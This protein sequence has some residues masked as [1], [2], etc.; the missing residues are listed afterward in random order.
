MCRWKLSFLVLPLLLA[1]CAGSPREHAE[2]APAVT[3]VSYAPGSLPPPTQCA[4]FVREITGIPLRG[5]AWTWW[6][7][8]AGRF[9]RGAAPKVDSVLV[10]RATDQLPYGHVA[11][12]RRVVG[13]REITVTHA[14]WGGDDPTR[15]LVHDS[16]P[17]VDVSPANDWS[18]LRFWN[19]GARAFGKVYAAYGFIYPSAG[20]E[21]LRPVW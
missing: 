7:Q 18:E 21:A 14:D 6:D 15:R 12:V 1:A 8:A 16:M 3:K 19:P 17:V 13:P 4:P 2:R 5:D 10:L 20:S 9:E 11:I